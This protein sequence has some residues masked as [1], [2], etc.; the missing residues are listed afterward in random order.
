MTLWSRTASRSSTT[1]TWWPK[2]SKLT[3]P[4]SCVQAV[5]AARRYRRAV[6]MSTRTGTALCPNNAST[7]LAPSSTD[8]STSSSSTPA[9]KPSCSH[10][11]DWCHASREAETLWP[12]HQARLGPAGGGALGPRES[13]SPI[14]RKACSEPRGKSLDVLLGE[15]IRRAQAG[16]QPQRCAAVQD[17]HRRG[18]LD[19]HPCEV[20]H[21]TP[22][23]RIRRDGWPGLRSSRCSALSV[24][25]PT[26][27]LTAARPTRPS[28][29]LR[30]ASCPGQALTVLPRR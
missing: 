6:L 14:A 30:A 2:R 9:S 3:N 21:E 23:S 15:R 29:W 26:Q 18:A 8:V 5:R 1:P 19:F 27:P 24:R 11:D 17:Q 28:T 12:K 25:S 16:G 20:Q 22:L 4:N 7:S 13:L 10:S